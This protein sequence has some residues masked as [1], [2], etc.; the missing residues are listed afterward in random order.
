MSYVRLPNHVVPRHLVIQVVYPRVPGFSSLATVHVCDRHTYRTLSGVLTATCPRRLEQHLQS[1]AELLQ[2]RAYSI[3]SKGM[4]SLQVMADAGMISAHDV[5]KLLPPHVIP[6][7]STSQL[8]QTSEYAAALPSSSR[9]S[10][11]AA[12]G[13]Y[14]THQMPAASPSSSFPAA[15]Q[16]AASVMTLASNRMASFTKQPAH[17]AARPPRQ[18]IITAT[19]AGASSCGSSS[20]RPST[21]SLVLMGSAQDSDPYYRPQE[22]GDASGAVSPALTSSVQ[23][24]QYSRPAAL[25]SRGRLIVPSV[26]DLER[27]L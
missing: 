13:V 5:P 11:C 17:A 4:A 15:P 12:P 8:P 25:P 2:S 1:R 19:A 3:L 9:P 21:S 6:A 20:G 23:S 7:M 27:M 18:L 22:T 14:P 26:R 10:I 24:V 16:A